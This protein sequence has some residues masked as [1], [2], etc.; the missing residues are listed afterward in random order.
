MKVKHF[1]NNNASEQLDQPG[2]GLPKLELL[3]AKHV[4]L[5]ALFATSTK[6]RALH[7][8]RRLVTE[9]EHCVKPLTVQDLA[10]RILVPKIQGMEDSSRFWSTAMALEHLIIVGDLTLNVIQ[11]LSGG[12]T[13]K[14]KTIGIKDV[15]PS[16][17]VN[18]HDIREKFVESAR[19]FESETSN[20]ILQKSDSNTYPHEWFGELNAFQWLAFTP[21]HLKIHLQQ[22]EKIK[23]AL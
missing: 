11:T 5:P 13:D 12:K 18:C 8:Y 9:I 14:L 15:K 22:I 10:R 20:L 7:E 3:I 21:M 4:L 2:G 23:L 1:E 17:L 16:E 19:R 6:T